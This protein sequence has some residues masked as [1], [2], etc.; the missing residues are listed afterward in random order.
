MPSAIAAANTSSAAIT[1]HQR[2]ARGE[3]C[4]TDARFDGGPIPSV[5]GGNLG[6][7][8]RSESNMETGTGDSVAWPWL[9]AA[10]PGLAVWGGR[11]CN[12]TG[13]ARGPSGDG[14]GI[15]KRG[16]PPCDAQIA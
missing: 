6:A 14:V 13:A 12:P 7:D 10:L 1:S 4:T 5:V 9:D 2:R 3:F 11:G 15:L 8:V 16:T